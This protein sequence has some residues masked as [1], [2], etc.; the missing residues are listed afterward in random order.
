MDY[1]LFYTALSLILIH[2]MDAILN[3]EW[4]IFPLISLLPSKI[5]YWVFCILHLPLFL[6]LFK[7]LNHP[8]TQSATI[9]GMDVFFIIHVGLHLLFLMHPKNKFTSFFSWSIITLAGLFGLA[10]LLLEF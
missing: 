10:S 1:L 9:Y 6:L 8:E 4:T 2:E 7:A 5:G 3:E